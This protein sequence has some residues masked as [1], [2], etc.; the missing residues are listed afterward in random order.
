MVRSTLKVV[1]TVRARLATPAPPGFSDATQVLSSVP[2]PAAL[3]A[4]FFSTAGFFGF[5][6]GS[7]RYSRFV[8]IVR[9][10]FEA[11]RLSSNEPE[12]GTMNSRLP[13]SKAELIDM[14]R[15]FPPNAA[16]TGNTAELQLLVVRG[17]LRHVSKRHN[18]AAALIRGIPA[19]CG[20]CPARS[21]PGAKGCQRAIRSR[22][23]MRPDVG[24]ARSMIARK[25]AVNLLA[26]LST[27]LDLSS[28]ALPA[29][30]ISF[31]RRVFPPS[32]GSPVTTV[33]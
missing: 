29:R 31:S 12:P 25:L 19:T 27:V 11:H 23:N 14:L 2:H 30:A 5:L 20:L 16:R 22:A 33:L 18:Q 13:N 6:P 28:S 17:F 32:Q 21:R 1:H 8:Q 9:S 4:A 15:L 26:Y 3:R 10:L 24:S 7:V